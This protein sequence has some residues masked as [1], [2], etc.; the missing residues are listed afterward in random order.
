VTASRD[1]VTRIWDATTGRQDVPFPTTS[2]WVNRAELSPDGRRVVT[3]HQGANAVIWDV[4]TRTRLGA[5]EGHR[6]EVTGASYSTDASL[7]VTSSRDDTVRIWDA[8]RFK[9][10]LVLRGHHASVRDVAFTAA[11]DVISVGADRTVRRWR[12]T[13]DH[14][15]PAEITALV[16]CR[17][18][19]R[20]DAN[21]SLVPTDIDRSACRLTD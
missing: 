6:R 13:R 7:I 3:A 20:V 12:L 19:L 15:T 10:L 8:A 21:G 2:G 11:G 16:R 17:V 9:M 4:A 18:A 5:L 14:R 1:G